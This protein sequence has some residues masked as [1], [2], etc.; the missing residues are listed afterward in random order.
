MTDRDHSPTPS[1]TPLLYTPFLIA[2]PGLHGDGTGVGGGGLG[3]PCPL[4]PLS[5]LAP[6][7]Q[8]RISPSQ[9]SY[10]G[11][12]PLS[13]LNKL[14]SSV[15]GG[16][17]RLGSHSLWSHNSFSPL[18]IMRRQYRRWWQSGWLG[19]GGRHRERAL[20]SPESLSAWFR[21]LL[22]GFRL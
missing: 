2:P 3:G 15:G 21:A 1:N 22:L 4:G 18:H 10:H 8:R 13:V 9:P 20:C 7:S 16:G 5:L 19:F 17:E 12:I 14:E 11:R 6:V